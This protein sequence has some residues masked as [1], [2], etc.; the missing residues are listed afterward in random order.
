VI[1]PPF[2]EVV[3]AT[4]LPFDLGE[5]GFCVAAA[6][7]ERVVLLVWEVEII[8]EVRGSCEI[9]LDL[10]LDEFRGILSDLCDHHLLGLENM[11]GTSQDGQVLKL[12]VQFPL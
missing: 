5:R 8:D 6:T 3:M 10:S 12:Q 2:L 4:F 1:F 11:D 9:P 7:W